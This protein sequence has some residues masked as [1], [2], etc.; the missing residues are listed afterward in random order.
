LKAEYEKRQPR[1]QVILRTIEAR[2][3]YNIT[4]KDCDTL[5]KRAHTW[6]FCSRG[7]NTRSLFFFDAEG[8]NRLYPKG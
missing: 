8:L 6:K 5:C 7:Q 1:Y 4:R 3:G 2:T